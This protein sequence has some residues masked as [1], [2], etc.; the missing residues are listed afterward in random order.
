MKTIEKP[1][2]EKATRPASRWRNRYRVFERYVSYTG[3]CFYPGE[4]WGLKEWPSRDTAETYGKWVE[5]EGVPAE[6]LGAFPVEA[7]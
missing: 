1:R 6:Y 4:Q 7:A 5:T 3:H 2:T